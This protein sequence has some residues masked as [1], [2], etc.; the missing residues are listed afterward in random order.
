MLFL[1]VLTVL[2]QLSFAS[3]HLNQ[4]PL[5][6]SERSLQASGCTTIHEL[7]GDDQDSGCTI[8]VFCDN[9]DHAEE[10]TVECLLK[11]D[12]SIEVRFLKPL[13][14]ESLLDSSKPLYSDP[15]MIDT[16]TYDSCTS[17]TEVY[18]FTYDPQQQTSRLTGR[19]NVFDTVA[20]RT[21]LVSET[22][23]PLTSDF[24]L[25]DYYNPSVDYFGSEP[26]C[27][28]QTFDDI[29]MTIDGMP[30]STGPSFKCSPDQ[31]YSSTIIDCS[32]IQEGLISDPCNVGCRLFDIN[33]FYP[34]NTF[35]CADV[36]V[37]SPPDI[38]PGG[39]MSWLVPLMNQPRAPLVETMSWIVPLMNLLAE[40]MS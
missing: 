32:N 19:S 7:L 2:V 40:T 33:F 27:A 16:A 15:S 11:N 31:S 29:S 23:Y 13:R 5:S 10:D 38:L 6:G 14:C 26:V 22:R 4:M 18:V 9:I 17:M 3:A 8:E 20:P 28:V 39:D 21:G 24:D 36:P 30:C 25:C 35:T 1:V 34:D 37:Q 12:T